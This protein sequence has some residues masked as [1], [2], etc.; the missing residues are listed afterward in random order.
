MHACLWSSLFYCIAWTHGGGGGGGGF[1][2]MALSTL[3]VMRDNTVRVILSGFMSL[4]CT[5]AVNPF[6]WKKKRKKK[7]KKKVCWHFSYNAIEPIKYFMKW[8]QLCKPVSSSKICV[9]CLCMYV[10]VLCFAWGLV[11]SIDL[12]KRFVYIYMRRVLKCEFAYDRIWLS[13]GDPV[14]LTGR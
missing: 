3:P 12:R 6:V 7:R 9:W 14:W 10:F 5:I 2:F 11:L 13:V 4:S 1:F 8:C